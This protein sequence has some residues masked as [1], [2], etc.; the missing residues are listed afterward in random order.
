MESN[1][2]VSPK[3]S[4]KVKRI[5]GRVSTNKDIA[6]EWAIHLA[7]DND[8]FWLKFYTNNLNQA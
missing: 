4:V 2:R 6:D 7:S 5:K 1:S 8:N 3:A